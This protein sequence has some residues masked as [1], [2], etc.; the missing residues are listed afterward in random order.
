M[1]F[2]SSSKLAKE[3]KSK[4]HDEKQPDKASLKKGV[5]MQAAVLTEV[6]KKHANLP[7]TPLSELFHHA[8]TD[9]EL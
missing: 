8:D 7:N 1:T 6:D 3:L 9:P 4:V 5:N 2:I